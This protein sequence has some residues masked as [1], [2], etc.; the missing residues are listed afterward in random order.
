MYALTLCL[1]LCSAV[2]VSGIRPTVI[3]TL[4]CQAPRIRGESPGKRHTIMHGR[5]DGRLA[6]NEYGESQPNIIN[7]ESPASDVQSFSLPLNQYHNGPSGMNKQPTMTAH[8]PSP[9]EGLP[10]S[11]RASS[12]EDLSNSSAVPVLEPAA[13]P[14]S[15]QPLRLLDSGNME[16]EFIASRQHTT[17]SG[18]ADSSSN[19]GSSS[20]SRSSQWQHQPG[21]TNTTSW[22][23][24]S[25][26]FV[27]H[28]CWAAITSDAGFIHK[29]VL[30]YFR[31]WCWWWWCW[32]GQWCR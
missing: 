11:K 2:I 4:V 20:S 6:E 1:V 5:S 8:T 22:I 3:G 7:V 13:S 28:Q 30:N 15:S 23:W 16:S 29:C 32:H 17:S 12:S 10:A 14:Q 31:R 24:R 18:S 26:V 19:S 27:H 9:S 21:I 25:H